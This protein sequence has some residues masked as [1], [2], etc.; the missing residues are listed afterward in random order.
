MRGKEE[1]L[2]CSDLPKKM[3]W[4][5]LT[6]QPHT[7]CCHGVRTSTVV[8]Q[9]SATRVVGCSGPPGGAAHVLTTP[10]QLLQN[11]T[12]CVPLK[13]A[14]QLHLDNTQQHR[15]PFRRCLSSKMGL[16]IATTTCMHACMRTN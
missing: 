13:A 7:H 2:A 6:Y 4:H 14:S 16:F 10:Q 1:A 9:K 5:V 11:L 3:H 15:H 12:P 8:L